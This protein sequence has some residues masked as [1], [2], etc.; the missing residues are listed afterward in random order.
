MECKVWLGGIGLAAILVLIETS[1]NVKQIGKRGAI[2]I[3]IVLIET[4][5]NVKNV[6]GRRQDK[7]NPVLIE[8]SWNVKYFAV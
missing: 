6:R 4:S 7:I 2:H 5:W 8:T 3:H 1:W